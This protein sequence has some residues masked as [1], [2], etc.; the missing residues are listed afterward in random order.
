MQYPCPLGLVLGNEALGVEREV[1]EHCD[2]LVQI[3]MYGL[4]NSLN[5]AAAGAVV[6]FEV[7]R[8]WKAQG[9]VP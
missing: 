8:Q 9:E 2:E 4:K 6:V 3:P 1:L 5:V 7:L